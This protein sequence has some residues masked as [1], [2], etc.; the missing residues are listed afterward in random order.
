MSIELFGKLAN[1]STE[2]GKTAIKNTAV[3]KKATGKDLITGEK[4]GKNPMKFV[5][6]AKLIFSV[7]NIPQT[8]D[9]TQAFYRRW[10][11][12]EMT[13]VFTG[14]NAD[15]NIVDKFTTDNMLSAW[16][17]W[18]VE[19]LERL[20]NNNWR[21]TGNWYANNVK[22]W[23]SSHTS[24]IYRFIIENYKR[25]TQNFVDKK[26]VFRNY[27]TYCKE[28][29]IVSLEYPEFCKK[30][31]AETPYRITAKQKLHKHGWIG[32]EEKK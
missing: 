20:K 11:P 26:L 2:I 24:S 30:V 1:I 4:K 12:I 25:N 23:W 15:Y 19:G 5:N 28:K 8:Y 18:S 31:L 22:I 14:M 6:H 9:K 21:F 13:N 32:I 29:D 16:F 7:N 17:S 27:E 3:I 10:L